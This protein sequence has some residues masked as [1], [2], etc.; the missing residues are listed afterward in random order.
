MSRSVRQR[1]VTM[2]IQPENKIF[3]HV[4]PP[5]PERK[6]NV[7]EDLDALYEWVFDQQSTLNELNRQVV[8][9]F[10]L[11]VT[12]THGHPKSWA[13]WRLRRPC[14]KVGTSGGTTVTVPGSTGVPSLFVIDGEL[15]EIYADLTC[16]LSGS[17]AGGLD[18]GSIAADKPYYLY[19]V[20]DSGTV[21]IIASASDPGTGPTGYDVWTYLGSFATIEGAATIPAFH[22]SNGVLL[23]ERISDSSHTYA[24]NTP[25]AETYNNLPDTAKAGYFRIYVRTTGSVGDSGNIGPSSAIPDTLRQR[26]YDVSSHNNYTMGWVLILTAQTIYMQTTDADASVFAELYGWREDPTEYP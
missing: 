22:S 16:D 10:N 7:K 19:G 25:N 11:H 8:D 24:G 23:G 17:G 5:I 18:T 3:P 26:C 2:A 4:V 6:G 15:F 13:K 1:Y 9:K 20:R 12:G 14:F 21:A